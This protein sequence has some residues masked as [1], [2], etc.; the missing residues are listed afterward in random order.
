MQENMAKKIAEIDLDPRND[1]LHGWEM[2]RSPGLIIDYVY[3]NFAGE[4]A[5]PIEVVRKNG[6]YQLCCGCPSP[7]EKERYEN[8]AGHH[9]SIAH[10]IS[11]H[12]LKG[13]RLMDEHEDPEKVE[14]SNFIRVQDIVV[15]N[16]FSRDE[17]CFKDYLSY[18]GDRTQKIFSF[19]EDAVSRFVD[20]HQMEPSSNRDKLYEFLIRSVEGC[21]AKAV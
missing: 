5:P 19:T 2:D 8:Y 3:R 18:L 4:Q 14:R 1:E 21:I 13:C 12:I 16:G 9:R 10:D 7:I 11:G 6:V 15:S 17:S 20:Y